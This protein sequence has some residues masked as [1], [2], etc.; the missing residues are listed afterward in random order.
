ML[1][2]LAISIFLIVGINLFVRQPRFGKL[3]DG[4]RKSRIE[5]SLNY[6]N[7]AFKNLNFTPQLTGEGGFLQ[8]MK[9]FMNAKKDKNIIPFLILRSNR[10][11][12]FISSQTAPKSTGNDT[13]F[14]YTD[15]FDIEVIG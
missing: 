9:D 3:P 11:I 4:E 15:H 6:Q 8:M 10:R 5:N 12:E 14:Y 1:T 7:G 13:L 2:F